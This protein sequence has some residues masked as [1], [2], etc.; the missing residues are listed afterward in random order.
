VRIV[1]EAVELGP[2]TLVCDVHAYHVRDGSEKLVG[3]G[4]QVQRILPKDKLQQLIER[5]KQ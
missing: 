3:T 5:S 4:R 1:A 2:T